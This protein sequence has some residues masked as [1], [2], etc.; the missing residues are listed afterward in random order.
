MEEQQSLL[1]AYDSLSSLLEKLDDVDNLFLRAALTAGDLVEADPLSPNVSL[2]P[3]AKRQKTVGAQAAPRNSK[4]RHR[5]R[6]CT[7]RSEIEML[8]QQ[9]KCL[10]QHAASRSDAFDSSWKQRAIC[11]QFALERGEHE[12]ALLKHR[13]AQGP[14]RAAETAGHAADDAAQPVHRISPRG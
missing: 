9:L 4:T 2:P 13:L 6:V 1:M 12:N 7:L 11:E 14:R 8:Y 5:D 10:Q 3:K